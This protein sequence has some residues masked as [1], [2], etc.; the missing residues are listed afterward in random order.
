MRVLACGERAVLVEVVDSD[1]ALA[2]YRSLREDPPPGLVDVV[3]AARTVL[4][5]VD[6]VAHLPSGE[7]LAAL[8]AGPVREQPPRTV[9]I[10][11]VYDGPDLPE[12]AELARLDRRDVVRRHRD[13]AYTVGFIGFAPGFAYLTGLHPSLHVARRD[14]PRTRVR[15]GAVAIAGPYTGVYPT[16]SPGGWRIIG[17]TDLLLWDLSA[18]PPALL[19]PGDR[20]R[21][22]EVDW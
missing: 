11:V 21:F 14:T 3:P 13:A 5:T 2:L 18:Q 17:H 22:V 10:P 20:V 7:R 12:V 15:R 16:E 6:D 8:A 9:D 19:R 4:V 1:A